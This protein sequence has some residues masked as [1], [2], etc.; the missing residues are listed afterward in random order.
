MRSTPER[1]G[2]IWLYIFFV[3]SVGLSGLV[4]DLE[5][6]M[7]VLSEVFHHLVTKILGQLFMSALTLPNHSAELILWSGT[8]VP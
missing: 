7:W 2:K 4:D 6:V 5:A 8:E 1:L 3:G